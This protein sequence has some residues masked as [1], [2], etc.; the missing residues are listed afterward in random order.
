MVTKLPTLQ[1]ILVWLIFK[2]KKKDIKL[3]L[4]S[5]SNS[6]ILKLIKDKK[7]VNL[8]Y[9]GDDNNSKGKRYVEL[10]ALGI[11]KSG[12][13]VVRA[14]QLFGDTDTENAKWKLFRLDFITKID[15][16]GFEIRKPISDYDPTIPKFNPN[17]DKT[18]NRV[19]SIVK[20]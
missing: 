13:L 5:V 8:Y 1:V 2:M 3:L 15:Q 11:S 17:G 12:N 19:H 7:R 9:D 20:F 10:Y 16:T 4:E 14:Y 18:M 6:Q